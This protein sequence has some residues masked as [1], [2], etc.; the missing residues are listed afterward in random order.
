MKLEGLAAFVATVEKGSISAA[1]RYLGLPKSVVSDR[2]KEL[3]RSLGARLLQRTTRKLS[4]T[5]DGLLFLERARRIV[6]EAADA[7]AEIA[8][9]RSELTGPLRVSAPVTFGVLH[10]GPALY[11]F[12]KAH[13]RIELKL[14]LDDRSIDAAA[15]GFD[16]V[17]RHGR[18][19]DSRLVVRRLCAS[20]RVLVASPAYLDKHGT[21]ASI[22]ELQTRNA[23]LYIIRGADWSFPDAVKAAVVR[24]K[25]GLHVN[26]GLIMRDAA[27][28]GLGIA[29]LPTF[30][31][32]EELR[33]GSLRA[34]DVGFEA[35]GAEIFVAYSAHRAPGKL[36]ALVDHLRR[37]FG[38]PPYWDSGLDPG[39]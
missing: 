31:V 28:S 25:H 17:V 6:H 21:P 7:A 32:H 24:P 9:R 1:A 18:V 34:I 37:T 12:L 15:E 36:R 13:P 14:D 23:I 19:R 8:E 5:E 3:E 35:E 39:S 29:L 10:L 30:A 27:V 20:R 22:G 16:A 38:N 33:R 26:N 2:L 4:V 11:A